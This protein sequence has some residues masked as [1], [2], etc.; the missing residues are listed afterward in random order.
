MRLRPLIAGNWKMNCTIEESLNLVTELLELTKDNTST[1]ILITP[2][3]TSLQKVG[4][5]IKDSNIRLGAQNMHAETNGAFTGEISGKMLKSVGCE[6]VIIGHSERRGL[7]CETDKIVNKKTHSALRENLKPIICVGE[8]I[9]EKEAGETLTVITRQVSRAL[10]GFDSDLIKDITIAYEPIW[11]IGTGKSA[12]PAEAEEIHKFIR[13]LLSE[14]F[15]TFADV[16]RIIYGGS[17]KADTIDTLMAEENING[18]L[19]GGASLNAK[20]FARIANFS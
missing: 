14:L 3:F 16:V 7:F 20:D 18:A 2:P 8:T 17:V 15:G 13:G 5:L 12:A 11:A 19:V 1:E 9:E 4:E 10:E 6:Y